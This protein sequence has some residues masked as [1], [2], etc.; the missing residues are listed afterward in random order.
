MCIKILRFFLLAKPSDNTKF[1][2]FPTYSLVA[3]E[4]ILATHG[5]GAEDWLL[6][7]PDANSRDYLHYLFV[8]H[9]QELYYKRLD[10]FY[11]LEHSIRS[12]VP[13]FSRCVLVFRFKLT[14]NIK[15]S[16]Y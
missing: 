14:N 3:Y 5:L 15:D 6:T 11:Y 9:Y 4:V 2:F 13:H 12:T 10:N 8:V 1:H 16:K 7:S